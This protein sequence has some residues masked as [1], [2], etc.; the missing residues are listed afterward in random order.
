MQ[1]RR[2]ERRQTA[3][4]LYKNTMFISCPFCSK[5]VDDIV[6]GKT[7]SNSSVSLKEPLI[8]YCSDIC[9]QKDWQVRHQF[10]CPGKKNMIVVDEEEVK[11]IEK[12]NLFLR[13]ASKQSQEEREKE[14]ILSKVKL[15]ELKFEKV[16]GKGS[17]G[18]VQ[19]ATHRPTG[20]Q[21]AVKKLD[22]L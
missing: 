16:V 22:K 4:K 17:Y 8:I 11:H 14:E 6:N 2:V 5:G 21:V 19:L 18:V 1:R 13:K 3:S 9:R 12:T 20:L 10:D 15:N 7:P